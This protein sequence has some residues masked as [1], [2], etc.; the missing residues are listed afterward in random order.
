MFDHFHIIKLFNEKLTRLRRDLQQEAENGLGKP[1]LK[2]IRW[3]LLTAQASL[4][5]STLMAYQLDHWKAL[6]TRSKRCIK[7][8][9]AYGFRDIEF[10]KLKIMALHETKYVLVG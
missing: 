6:I 7:W 9:M 10:F 1:V 8:L 2:G 3:L 5:I 4:L